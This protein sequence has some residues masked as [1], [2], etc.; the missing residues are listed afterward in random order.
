MI[1]LKVPSHSVDRG[2]VFIPP[3]DDAWDHE[4]MAADM[5]AVEA[6]ALAEYQDAVEAKYRDAQ[7]QRKSEVTAEEVAAL[8]ESCVLSEEQREEAIDTLP[9]SRYSRGDTRF[10]IDCSDWDGEGKPCTLRGRYLTKGTPT[11][12]YL[13][14]L[15]PSDY[16][17]TEELGNTRERVL[18][19]C[20]L[21]LSGIDSGDFTWRVGDSEKKA[22]EDIIQALQDT[23]VSLP[24]QVGYAVIQFCRKLNKAEL[25]R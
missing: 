21:G 13:R 9:F 22:P 23:D 4:A 19:F 2:G 3:S 16:H 1:R 25:F 18:E 14:R 10:D 15:R 6:K 12:F 11:K 17:R 5:Q 24:M 7:R 20:R 8:R